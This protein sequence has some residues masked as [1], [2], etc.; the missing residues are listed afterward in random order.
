MYVYSRFFWNSKDSKALKVRQQNPFL[1]VLSYWDDG[2]RTSEEVRSAHAVIWREI[3]CTPD[4]VSV[5]HKTTQGQAT[6]HSLFHTCMRFKI[7][8]Q[9]KVH[10]LWLQVG[11]VVHGGKKINNTTHK[12]RRK[13]KP[14]SPNSTQK[15]PNRDL[16]QEHS[17][18]EVATLKQ[19]KKKEKN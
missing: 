15:G 4:R 6:V 17:C 19:T 5:H 14:L 1:S 12:H 18:C 7:S 13:I 16:N 10:I 9:P 3:E 2:G 11:A 8:F